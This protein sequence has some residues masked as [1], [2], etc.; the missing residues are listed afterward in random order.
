MTEWKN[1][2]YPYLPQRIRS[3][4]DTVP[5]DIAQSITELRMRAEKP[6]MC[7]CGRQPYR[8]RG[9]NITAEELK[10]ILNAIC[11]YS[12]YCYSERIAEGCITLPHGHRIGFCGTYGSQTMRHISGINIRIAHQI[13]GCAE[14][15]MSDNVVA[16]C[17][18]QGRSLIVCGAP[19][20]GKTTLLRDICRLVS[21]TRRV[22]LIDTRGEIAALYNGVPQLDVGEN[23]DVFDGGSRAFNIEKSV[24]TMSPQ[25]IIADEIGS[26]GDADAIEYALNSGAAVIS[27]AHCRNADE[28]RKR[29]PLSELTSAGGFY[30]ACFIEYPGKLIKTELLSDDKCKDVTDYA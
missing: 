16:D 29:K 27:T 5:Y 18:E 17:I 22:S 7:T 30:A 15:I 28:L 1:E 12:V 20:T 6:L 8:V 24:R 14:T 10:N 4:L 3:M 25:V 21:Q 23:T 13:K 19:L 11:E 26:K 9:E 2:V